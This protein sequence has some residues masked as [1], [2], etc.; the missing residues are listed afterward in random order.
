MY[1]VIQDNRKFCAIGGH[2]D[3]AS[4]GRKAHTG[5]AYEGQHARTSHLR[6]IRRETFTMKMAASCISGFPAASWWR[7]QP[8]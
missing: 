1:I 4:Q 2:K 8:A 6:K 5:G 3:K 7:M